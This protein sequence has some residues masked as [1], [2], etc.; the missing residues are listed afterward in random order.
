MKLS[1]LSVLVALV[2][3]G[4]TVELIEQQDQK[5]AYV[6]VIILLLSIIT[7]NAAAFNRQLQAVVGAFAAYPKAKKDKR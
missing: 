4:A 7:F 2:I 6:L 1:P 5:A 3:V